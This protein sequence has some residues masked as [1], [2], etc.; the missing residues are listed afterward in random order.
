MKSPDR[1]DWA[2]LL[3]L[4]FLSSLSFPEPAQAR[5]GPAAFGIA[6]LFVAALNLVLYGLVILFCICGVA[7]WRKKRTL[8]ISLIVVALL[9][10]L[11]YSVEVVRSQFEPERRSQQ[12]ASL[13]EHRIEPTSR[14]R[15]LQYQG[16]EQEVFALVAAGVVDEI[17]TYYQYQ[18]RIQVYTLR[19]G[20]EC[21]EF[22]TSLSPRAEMRRAILARHAFLRCVK[23][24]RREG[25]PDAPVQLFTG[26]LAPNFYTGPACLGGGNR[27][28]ELRWTAQN[29]GALIS[30]WESSSYVPHAFPP[31]LLPVYHQVWDCGYLDPDSPAYQWPEPFYF[32]SAALGFKSMDDFSKASTPEIVPRTLQVLV[33]KLGS[34]YAHDHVLALLGQWPSTPA[35]AAVLDDERIAKNSYILVREAATILTEPGMD[36]RRKLLYPYLATH[37]RSLL[38]ICSR[39]ADY[40]SGEACSRL[41]GTR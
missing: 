12:L 6:F 7:L 29:G 24:T 41:K 18:N 28:L 1:Y 34:R 8:A 38:K 26:A 11:H 13:M 10:F 5:G 2:L 21:I 39:S 22:E 30:F 37:I 36:E 20:P 27:P 33:T 19:E 15:A 40:R 32:A 14:V 16:V 4:G 35:I 9:P 23:E 3:C 31:R 25:P 17:Q